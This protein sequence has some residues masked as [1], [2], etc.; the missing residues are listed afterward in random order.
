MAMQVATYR[1]FGKQAGTYEATQT[2]VFLHG[3]T[4]TTR[5]VSPASNA[6]CKLMGLTPQFDEHD[7]QKRKEKLQLLKEAVTAHVQYMGKAGQGK[8]VDRHFLGL[9]LCAKEGEDLPALYSDPTFIR[10]KR[11]RVSTSNLTHPL[12]DN[13]GYGEVVPDGVGLSY[14]V[15]PR[16]CMFNVTSLKETGWSAKLCQLLEEALLEMQTLIEI[17][18][19]VTGRSK[20]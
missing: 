13:W 19:Q 20:L 5:S 8:G 7:E 4:E 10:S 6:F 15:H 17:D 16:Y 1:L 12:F 3:R 18:Q 11:W 9:S 14:S 2:R